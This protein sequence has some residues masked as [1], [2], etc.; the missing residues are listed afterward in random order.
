MVSGSLGRAS[1]E[2]GTCRRH[3]EL[4]QTTVPE[5]LYRMGWLL[6]RFASDFDMPNVLHLFNSYGYRLVKGPGFSKV[7]QYALTMYPAEE[8]ETHGRG[9]ES[10]VWARTGDSPFQS[11]G[12]T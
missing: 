12:S 11:P 2:H 4:K 6:N 10:Y 9:S 8:V 7:Q 5:T 1:A 3:E